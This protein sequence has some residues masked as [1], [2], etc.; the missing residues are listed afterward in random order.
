VDPRVDVG[1]DNLVLDP[2]AMW[3]GRL[4]DLL[5]PTTEAGQGPNVRLYRRAAEVLQQVVVQV[6][7]VLARLTG[8]TFME[9]CEV[10]IDKVRKWLRWVHA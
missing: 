10:F 2:F 9:I 7:A 1:G 4:V 8:K 3:K 5:K 6:D